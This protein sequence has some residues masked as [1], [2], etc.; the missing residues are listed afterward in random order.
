MPK[1]EDCKFWEYLE[2]VSPDTASGLCRRK[3][4]H[5]RSEPEEMHVVAYWPLVTESDWCGEFEAK[6]PEAPEAEKIA[7]GVKSA[8]KKRGIRSY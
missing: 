7:D 2:M 3:A 5:V 1:C 8:A 4:P 6:A